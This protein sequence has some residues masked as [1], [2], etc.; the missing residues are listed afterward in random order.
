MA[1]TTGAGARWLRRFHPSPGGRARLACFPHAGGSASFYFSLS[2]SLSA[3]TEV[4]AVQY[5]GRQDRAADKRVDDI[6][7][8]ADRVREALEAWTDRPLALF[9]HS[10]GAVVAFE[11]ARRLERDAV[12]PVALIAS[13]RRAPSRHRHETVHLLDDDGLVAALRRLGGTDARL[14]AD[15][16]LRRMILPAVRSDYKAIETYRCPAGSRLSCPTTVFVGDSDPMTTLDEARAWS[17]HTTG[18]FDLRVFHGGH[19]YIGHH[20]GQVTGAISRCLEA[21]TA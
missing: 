13:S 4:L 21:G 5:P 7:E 3:S 15:E 9:G 12:T 10:M 8:L 19:F 16:E 14:L 17:E 2:A 11:V 20:Q 6:P 1:L 18:R